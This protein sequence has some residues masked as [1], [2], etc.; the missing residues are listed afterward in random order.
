MQAVTNPNKIFF[1]KRLVSLK[2]FVS[3][4]NDTFL[5]SKVD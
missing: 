3:E 2:F 1:L 4:H 5:A